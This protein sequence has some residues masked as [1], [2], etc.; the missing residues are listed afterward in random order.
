[1]NFQDIVLGSKTEI[2]KFLE[3][4]PKGIVVIRGATATGKS[5]LSIELSKFFDIEII[6]SDSRQI[7][8]KMDIG[9]DKVSDEILNQIPHH[10]VNIIDP[11]Q[12]YTSGEWQ[13]DVK[14]QIKE[15]QSRGK[16]PFIVGG[17]G[18]Y[19]DTIYKNFD[20]PEIGPDLDFRKEMFDLENK[21]AGILHKRLSEIDPEEAKKHHPNSTRYI[22]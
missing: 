21:E 9:T 6:S 1:M 10:Q 12:V 11:D 16:I 7:F 18:L 8:R 19:I 13:K 4:N 15:I 3:K 20:M 22:V 2:E 5:K 17:T 14:K